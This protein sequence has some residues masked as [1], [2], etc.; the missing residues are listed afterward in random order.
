MSRIRR[1]RVVNV[2][3]EDAYYPD[4]VLEFDGHDTLVC[5]ANGGGKTTLLHHLLQ[6]VRPGAQIDRRRIGDYFGSSRRTVHVAIE[7]HLDEK[8][9]PLLKD[10]P[11]CSWQ[12][13]ASSGGPT[14]R[15]WTASATP[16]S[17]R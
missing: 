8:A 7:F 1:V 13:S 4:V 14:P 17:I 11:R 3:H 6:V 9:G 2:G 10:D 5:L 15:A 16:A 12:G